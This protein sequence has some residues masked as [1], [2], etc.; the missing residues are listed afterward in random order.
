[1]IVAA[2]VGCAPSTLSFLRLAGLF[3]LL[4]GVG[5]ALLSDASLDAADVGTVGGNGRLR[6]EALL[7][8]LDALTGRALLLR[9][10]EVVRAGT[11]VGAGRARRTSL[12]IAW[13]GT[14]MAVATYG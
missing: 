8:V 1:M 9:N 12:L 3:R 6:A 14:A 13:L 2:V 10:W 5:R 7:S 4:G 11:L